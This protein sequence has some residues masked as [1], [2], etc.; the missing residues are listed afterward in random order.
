M[1]TPRWTINEL[2]NETKKRIENRYDSIILISGVTGSGKS[3]FAIKFLNHFE[4]FI[5]KNMLVYNRT[6]MIKMIQNFEHSY[7]FADELIKNLN[8]R[9]FY[10]TEQIELIQ[11]LAMYRSSGNVFVGCVPIFWSLDSELLKLVSCHIHIIKRG[12]GAIFFP[13]EGRLFN[14]DIWYVR[15]SQ[16]L[17]DDFDKIQNKKPSAKINWRKYPTFAGFIF[18]NPLTPKQEQEYEILKD[19]KRK[20]LINPDGKEIKEDFYE[21]ILKIIKEG[22]L[23]EMELLKIC[24]YRE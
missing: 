12:I 2:A 3:N 15:Q 17:E 8:K 13:K 5:L 21:K 7:I 11:N 9:K 10:D 20:L 19:T 23:T 24:L 6:E 14:S 18:F 4:G 16:K 1:R 22:N